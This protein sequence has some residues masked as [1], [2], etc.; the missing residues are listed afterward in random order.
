MD[1]TAVWQDMLSNT[2]VDSIGHNTIA[3]KTTGHEKTKVSV[4]LTAKADRTKLKP[5]IVFPGAKRETK[6]LNEEFKA[7]CVVA[8]SSNGWMKEELTLDWV[9]SVLGKFSFTRRIL[10]WD[11]FKCH[12]IDTVKQELRTSKIDPLIVPGGCTKYI[13]APDVVWNKPFKAN[14][15]EKYDEWMAGEAHSF[16]AVG[17]MRAPA[18]REIVKWI[19]AAWDGLDK[20]MIINSFKSCALTVAVDGSDDGHIHCFKENQPCRAGLQRLKVVQQAMSNSRDKDPFDGITESDVE[21]AA[22][23]SL[24]ID[25]SDTEV[26]DIEYGR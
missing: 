18:R 13:Q 2:T 19:L 4:C 16:T 1:E 26:I 25:V 12:V 11:S 7:K 23:D 15:T 20:T 8:S 6:L 22:P 3:M 24:I 10:A 5:F 9:R 21:D 14:V 17:N